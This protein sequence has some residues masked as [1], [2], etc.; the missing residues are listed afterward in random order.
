LPV[1]QLLKLND[2]APSLQSRYR[3]FITTTRDSAPAPRFGT[4]T[5]TGRPLESLPWHR[6]AG[7]HVPHKSLNRVHAA[8]VPDADWAVNRY[9]PDLSQINDSPLVL[10]SSLRFR[11]VISGSLAFVSSA[12]T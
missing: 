3:T 7:S 2:V 6:C 5:L 8:F 10:T 11:Q 4:L 12:L 9:P 1:D